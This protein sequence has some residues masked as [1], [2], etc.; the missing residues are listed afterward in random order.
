MHMVTYKPAVRQ[1]LQ[2][3]PRKTAKRIMHK[4]AN[5]VANPE[6]SDATA[7]TGRD[8]ICLRVGNL[9]VILQG[10]EVIALRI[11]D[12]TIEPATLGNPSWT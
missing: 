4:I 9:R 7:L 1:A 6:M 3:M 8:G 10:C 11:V 12:A 2:R 5:Y